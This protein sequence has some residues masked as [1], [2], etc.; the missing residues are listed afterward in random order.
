MA[1]SDAV[2]CSVRPREHSPVKAAGPGLA[3]CQGR[4]E[5]SAGTSV[6]P[7]RWYVAGS[8][9][10]SDAEVSLNLDNVGCECARER[11]PATF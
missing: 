10:S 6:L 2:S 1:G 3:N 9:R 4:R 7:V 8:A 11:A 5:H